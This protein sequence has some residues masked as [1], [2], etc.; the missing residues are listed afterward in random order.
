LPIAQIHDASYYLIQN[1]LDVL[2][3]VNQELISSMQWCELPEI[4][5]DKVKLEAELCLYYPSWATEHK[6]PNNLSKKELLEF[7]I[8]K[9]LHR[10]DK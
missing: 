6:I 2:Y 3:W 1:D 8:N 5:H 7:L 9:K 4:K 10:R